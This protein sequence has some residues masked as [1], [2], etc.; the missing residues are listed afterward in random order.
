[1][2]PKRGDRMDERHDKNRLAQELMDALERART[3]TVDEAVQRQSELKQPKVD[4]R[5]PSKGAAIPIKGI[6]TIIK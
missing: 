3:T 2:V 5:A 1:M 4:R 6:A